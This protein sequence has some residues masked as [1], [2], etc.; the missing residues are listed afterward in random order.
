MVGLGRDCIV[1]S[2]WI[3]SLPGVAIFILTLSISTIGDWLRDKTD[4]S[5]Q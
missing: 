4:P 5:L 1:T 2:W 3:A